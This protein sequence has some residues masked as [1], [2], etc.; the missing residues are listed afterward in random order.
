MKNSGKR[1]FKRG[2]IITSIVLAS[3]IGLTA[4]FVGVIAIVNVIIFNAHIKMIGEIQT[5]ETNTVAPVLSEDSSHWTFVTDDEFKVLQLTD[6]HIGAGAFSN[7]K[8][9]WAI[10]AVTTLIQ[11]E[12]PNQIGRAHV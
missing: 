10:N 2:C 3:I 6:I 4:L 11:E 12:K 5:V 9:N 7:K 8:D 1:N